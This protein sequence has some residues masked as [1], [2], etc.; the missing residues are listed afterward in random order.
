MLQK[1]FIAIVPPEPVLQNI[2]DIKKSIYNNYGTKGALRSPA[3]ITLH[4]P[5]S[6]DEEKE[7]K[8]ISVL[9]TLHQPSSFSIQLNGFSCFEPRVLFINVE[10]NQSLQALQTKLVQLCKQKLQLFNQADDLR[11]FHP[12]VT[13][14]FRDL[15][16]PV[17][18]KLWEEYQQKPF[19]TMFQCSS[20]CLMKQVEDKWEVYKT[21]HFISSPQ[22]TMN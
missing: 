14:A 10:D 17:F 20:F 11:G 3:H 1:Y 15:K 13:V 2:T 7:E 12:H 5:F 19:K 21:F 18:Y 8:L 9:Q 6:W 4:M 16:K 22:K